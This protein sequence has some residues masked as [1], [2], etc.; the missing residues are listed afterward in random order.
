MVGDLVGQVLPA[1]GGGIGR[2]RLHRGRQEPAPMCPLRFDIELPLKPSGIPRMS[3]LV[4][5]GNR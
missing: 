2:A 3:V 1:P 5:A 4:E